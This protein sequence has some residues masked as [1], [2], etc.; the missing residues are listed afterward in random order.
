[1][2]IFPV[3][4]TSTSLDI[5][6][7]HSEAK[8]PLPLP[9]PSQEAP[10][11]QNQKVDNPQEGVMFKAEQPNW[12][13]DDVILPQA[14]RVEIDSALDRIRHQETLFHDWG[15][16]KVDPH[17]ARSV[18]NF[19]GPPGTGK[20]MCAEAIAS[21]MG[22]PIIKVNYADLESKYVGE[23]PKNIEGAF[24]AAR[25]QDAV[26]FFDEA[27]SILGKRL[28]SVTQ[29]ADHSVNLSRSVM[30]LAMDRFD[31][32][33]LFATNLAQNYDEAFVR[34]IQSHIRFEL[35]DLKAR[36]QICTRMLVE[37]LPRADEVTAQSFAA[38]S[39]G[40]SGGDLRTVTLNAASR[41]VS[42][43]G[44]A[45]KVT[46]EDL[47]GCIEQVRLGKQEV[48]QQAKSER[49]ME[50]REEEVTPESLPADVRERYDTE[51]THHEVNDPE[52]SA[53]PSL[54]LV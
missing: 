36:E 33:V 37:R 52:V 21:Y 25:E 34:R 4:P 7:D 17:G 48:A 22:K 43:E 40:L 53:E 44:E 49:P 30:L 26:I 20:S 32:V 8:T 27:D 1:M 51:V 12:Q 38:L 15:L 10:S 28:S 5:P 16:S 14:V 45:R 11:S 39:E 9:A 46:L 3:E 54:D 50:V 41:A 24:E 23:T 47:Q 42:R 6:S 29:G 31:G 19:Y 35:P 18:L 13:I 2:S